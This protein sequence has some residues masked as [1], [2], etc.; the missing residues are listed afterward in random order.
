VP[1]SS[2]TSAWDEQQQSALYQANSWVAVAK[3]SPEIQN[4]GRF[5]V[6]GRGDEV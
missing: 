2:A 6:S 4:R 1:T 5:D 3:K